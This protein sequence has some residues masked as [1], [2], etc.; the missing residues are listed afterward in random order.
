MLT[1]FVHIDHP[2]DA[3]QADTNKHKGSECLFGRKT[4]VKEEEGRFD[5]PVHCVVHH[6]LDKQPLFFG[7]K[8]F[9]LS[10]V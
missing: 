4:Q 2:Y 3:V 7:Q 5:D 9:K 1:R 6:L 8:K 10:E